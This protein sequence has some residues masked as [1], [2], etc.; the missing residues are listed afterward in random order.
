MKLGTPC[1]LINV[2]ASSIISAAS[3]DAS[4]FP[5]RFR[6]ALRLVVSRAW[7]AST[8]AFISR[9]T[10]SMFIILLAREIFAAP[11]L[12]GH[13]VAFGVITFVFA[14]AKLLHQACGSVSDLHRNRQIAVFLCVL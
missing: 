10:A 14:I 3:S 4:S 7:R 12:F 1:F 9:A 8:A 6:T 2:L 13:K 11:Q 5:N